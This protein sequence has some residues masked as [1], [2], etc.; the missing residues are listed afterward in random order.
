VVDLKKRIKSALEEDHARQ[1]I[2]FDNKTKK[3]KSATVFL[4]VS[5]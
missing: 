4:T 5:N 2:K 1:K 3:Q